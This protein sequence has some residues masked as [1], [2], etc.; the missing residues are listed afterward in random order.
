MAGSMN[1][2]F[3]TLS[4][5]QKQEHNYSC[6]N[7]GCKQPPSSKVL[8]PPTGTTLFISGVPHDVSNVA[9]FN[10]APGYSHFRS[11]C[12]TA[13]LEGEDSLPQCYS[14]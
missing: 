8:A 14:I 1:T 5:Y 11:F 3:P 6:H 7:T 2:P 4:L 10:L 13:G 12:A 9:T